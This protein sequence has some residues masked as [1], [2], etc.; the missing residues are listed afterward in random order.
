MISSL[1]RV[2]QAH[3]SL[4]LIF[5]LRMSYDYFM[6]RSER[7]REGEGRSIARRLERLKLKFKPCDP[8]SMERLEKFNLTCHGRS[9]IANAQRCIEFFGT[10]SRSLVCADASGTKVQ[11][12]VLM[13]GSHE[14]LKSRTP[15]K[16]L[17]T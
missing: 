7:R 16:Y 10:R 8:T 15:P 6:S 1:G 12:R 2:L 14:C 5:A 4:E 11:V 3:A 9:N 13:N 17:R